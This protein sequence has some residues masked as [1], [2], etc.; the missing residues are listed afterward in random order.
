MS[1]ILVK[2]THKH[3]IQVNPNSTLSIYEKFIKSD[4]EVDVDYEEL[5]RYLHINTTERGQK[6]MGK[7]SRSLIK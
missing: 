1:E 6:I 4:I 5:V 3:L 7:G 2:N